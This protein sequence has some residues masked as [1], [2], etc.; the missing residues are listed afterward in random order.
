MRLQRE[1]FGKQ[2]FIIYGL[3]LLMTDE[4][5]ASFYRSVFYEK[6]SLLL[7]E[8]VQTEAPRKE[9]YVIVIDKDLCVLS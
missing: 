8:P 5:L 2:V 9:E 7:I 3:K 6:L 4:E 1:F